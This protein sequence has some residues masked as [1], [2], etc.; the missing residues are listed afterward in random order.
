MKERAQR[1]EQKAWPLLFTP[2]QF[3]TEKT[4]ATVTKFTK[5][6]FFML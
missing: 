2:H 1:D 5:F 6:R 4:K 3:S